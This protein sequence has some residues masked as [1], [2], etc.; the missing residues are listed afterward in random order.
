MFQPFSQLDSALTRSYGGT[1]LGLALVRRL[2][3]L[4]GGRVEVQ[5]DLH[6]GTRFSV[7]LPLAAPAGDGDRQA[8][9]EE[10]NKP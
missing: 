2:A 5:G 9:P 8:G 10:E 3:E 4:H 1:G 6:M 7:V